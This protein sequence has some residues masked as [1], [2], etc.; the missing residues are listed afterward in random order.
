MPLF[1]KIGKKLKEECKQKQ[2]DMHT[3]NIGISGNNH[4]V[5]P[6]IFNSVFNIQCSLKQVELFVFINYLLGEAELV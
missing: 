1:Y 6:Q 2:P 4:I 3:V 5:I